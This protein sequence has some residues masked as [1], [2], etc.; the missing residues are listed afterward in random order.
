MQGI[1]IDD[2]FLDFSYGEFKC[3][4]CK[5]NHSDND[6]F[7]LN[8]INDSKDFIAKINCLF[9][10]KPFLLTYNYLGEMIPFINQD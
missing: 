1:K 7:Y 8:K 3:P 4:H 5:K 6:D 10:K 9:C 2:G